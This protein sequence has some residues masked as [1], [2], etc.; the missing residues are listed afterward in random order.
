[1]D[2]AMFQAFP[3]SVSQL[4]AL[5]HLQMRNMRVY[6]SENVVDLAVL[7]NLS[8]LEFGKMLPEPDPAYDPF[9]FYKVLS[10]EELHHLKQLE[11]ACFLRKSPLVRNVQDSFW[12]NI[13]DFQ[14]IPSFL[15]K[16]GK[17]A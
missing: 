7:P 9:D 1:M 4:S 5:D 12:Q 14:A 17:A 6:F 15:S 13:W 16:H 8:T 10:G 3:A 2:Y 11:S